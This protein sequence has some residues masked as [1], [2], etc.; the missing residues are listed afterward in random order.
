MAARVNVG[1]VPPRRLAGWVV[2]ASYHVVITETGVPE[3][4]LGEI[5]YPSI[6]PGSVQFPPEVGPIEEWEGWMDGLNVGDAAG[7]FA[8]WISTTS[9]CLGDLQIEG[10]P[11]GKLPPMTLEP[12]TFNPQVQTLI[13]TGVGPADFWICWMRYVP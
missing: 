8:W 6:A 10:Y 13:L 4:A 1:S 11:D 12:G 7:T 5:R 2:D 3:G 9:G